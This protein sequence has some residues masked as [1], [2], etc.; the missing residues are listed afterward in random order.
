[1]D[2]RLGLRSSGGGYWEGV[3]SNQQLN[4]SIRDLVHGGNGTP[5]SVRVLVT[6]EHRERGSEIPLCP[7]R[8]CPDVGEGGCARGGLRPARLALAGRRASSR[9]G[10]PRSRADLITPCRLS[11][12][13]VLHLA[14]RGAANP[15][16]SRGPTFFITPCRLRPARLALAGRRAPSRRCYFITPCVANVLHH[17]LRASH[18]RTVL[19]PWA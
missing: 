19:L 8:P 16:R 5:R 4:D 14:V 9:R 18:G 2:D 13:D 17:A 7:G 12:V 10:L 6:W 3:P 1:M 15:P 11:Q